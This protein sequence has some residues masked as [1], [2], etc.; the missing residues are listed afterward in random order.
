[1][2]L[3]ALVAAASLALAIWAPSAGAAT[4][5]WPSLSVSGIWA[6]LT[7]SDT[8][9]RVPGQ[10]LGTADGRTDQVPASVTRTQRN[11][12]GTAPGKG[13]GQLPAYGAHSTAGP[14]VTSGPDTHVSG[15]NSKTS[16]LVPSDMTATQDVYQNSNGTYTRKVYAGP[17]N[18]ETS[19]GSYAPIDTTLVS[20]GGRWQ[21]KANSLGVSFAPTSGAAVLGSMDLGG[22]ESYGFGLA[23]ATA[24]TGTQSGSSVTYPGVLA[25]TDLQETASAAGLSESLVLHSAAAPS[26][27]IFPLTL[28]GLTPTLGANGSVSLVNSA[29]T[30]VV[31]IPAGQAWDSA[32]GGR[33]GLPAN[34]VPTTWQLVS[35]NGSPALQL[36]LPAGWLSDPSRVFP[37]TVDPT[38]DEG[39]TGTTYAEHGSTDVDNSGAALMPVGTYDQGADE[40]LTFLAFGNLGDLGLGG[41]H[42]T[43]ASLALFDAWAWQ[44][45][46]AEE[47]DAYDITSPWSLT[48]ITWPGPSTGSEMGSLSEVAPTAACTNS[49]PPN[50]TVGGWMV[51][52]LNST[53]VADINAWTSYGLG[54][55]GSFGMMLSAANVGSTGDPAWKQFDGA[56][57]GASYEPFLE[58]TYATDTPPQINAVYPQSNYNA[59]SLTPEL[60]ASGSD[61]GNGP[62]PLGYY[63]A[64][65]NSAGTLVAN[66]TSAT[67]PGSAPGPTPVCN[68]SSYPTGWLSAPDWTVPENEL[69][70]GQTYYWTAV[71]CDGLY[72]GSSQAAYLTTQVPQPTVGQATQ[73]S[74][75]QGV[76][77]GGS[78]YT[79][80]ATDAQVSTIGPSLSIERDYDSQNFSAVGAFGAGWSSILDMKVT[81]ALTDAAGNTDTVVVTYPD[82]SQVGFG[83]N[84]DGSFTAPEGRYATLASVSGGYTLTDKNDT[85]YAFTQPLGGGAYGISSITDALGNELAFTWNSSDEITQMTSASGRSLSISWATPS[86]AQN[87]HVSS[88]STNPVTGTDQ[89][90]DLTWTYGYSGDELT[91]VC[92]PISTTACTTYSYTAGTDYPDAVLATS[93]HSYWRLDESSGATAASS[94]LVN[95]QTDAAT[96]SNVTLGAPGPLP[97]ST[98]TAA[99][100]NGSSSYVTL[101]SSL[102]PGSSYQS[103]SLWFKTNGTNGANEVLLG[104]QQV[105]LSGS[106]SP[107]PS[108]PNLYIGQDGKLIGEFWGLSAPL[109]SS[110]SVT[111]GTWYLATLVK[112]GSTAYLY[113]DGEQVA[114]AAETPDDL[115]WPYDYVGAGY[116]GAGWPDETYED[117]D[118]GTYT[119]TYFNGSI[120]DVAIW[121]RDLTGPEI[122]ALYQAGS[123]QADQLS[124]V[125]RPSGSV[126]A[127]VAYSTVTGAVSQVT[128]D[129]GGTWK[130][131]VPTVNYSSQVYVASVL[132]QAPTDYWRLGDTETSTAVNQVGGGG[133]ATYN[134]V[135]QGV[136]GPF[137]DSTADSF[138]GTSSY[139]QLPVADQVQTGSGSVEMWFQVPAGNTAGGVL[140][141][142][143][144]APLGPNPGNYNPALYVGTD[145]KLHGG[146]WA[147][148][149]NDQVV[150]SAAVNDGKWHMVVLTTS[151]TSESL[152]LDGKLLGTLSDAL[153][154]TG[155]ADVYVGAGYEYLWPDAPTNNNYDGYFTGS[156]SDVAFF[157]TQLSAAQVTAQWQAAGEVEPSSQGYVASVLRQAPAD[158]WRL[159]DTGTSTAVNQVSDGGTATYNDVAEGVAGPFA[160]ST[161]DSFNGTSSYLQ[162]PV[163]D[164]VQT[165]SGSVEMWFRVPAGNTAGGVLWDEMNSALGQSPTNWAPALYVGTDGILHGGFW[166]GSTSDQVVS[167]SAVNDGKWHMVVLTTS[168]TDEA[169]Y[170]DGQLLGTLPDELQPTGVADIY[171]GAGYVASWPDA[172]ANSS[173]YFTGSI[174]DVASFHTELSAAQVTAQWQAAQSAQGLT[175]VETQTVTDPG[176]H[177]ISYQMDPLNEDRIIAQTDALGDTTTFGYDSNGFQDSVTDP[178]GN[179]TLTGHDV[180]GNV[181]SQTTCQDWAAQDCSTE[182]MTYYP[183]DTSATLSPSPMNDLMLSDAGPGSASATDPTYLTTYT[184]TSLGEVQTETGPPVPGFPSGRT[185][186]YTYSCNPAAEGCTATPAY[187]SSGQQSGTTPPGLQLTETTPG[188]AVTSTEYY[189]DG[190]VYQVTDPDGMRTV[191]TYD[192][193]GRMLTQTEYSSSY[194]AGLTTTYAYDQMGQVV[195]ETDPTVT[196]PLPGTPHTALTT[197]TYDP[198]G[199]VLSQTVSDTTPASEGGDPARTVTNTYNSHDQLASTTDATG[200]KTSYTYDAYGNM[201]TKT[202]PA[203]NVTDYTYDADGDLLT[204]VLANYT[205]TAAGSCQTVSGGLVESSRTYDPAG[206]LASETNA[207]CDTTAYTYT[208]NGL[209]S[210]VTQCSGWTAS[211]GC[212]GSTYVEQANTYNSAGQLITQVTDNGQ[213]TTDYA[214][215]AAGQTESQTLD[216]A[217]LDRTTTYSYSPDDAVLNQKVFGP[218]SS[219]PPVTSVT[220]QA[221]GGGGGGS[222]S[223]F[224]D[225]CAAPGGGGGEYASQS[226]A[227]IPGATY[228][229]VVGAGGAGGAAG[230]TTGNAGGSSSFT[231]ESTVTA[232]GGGAGSIDDSTNYGGAGG[233]GGSNTTRYTGGAGGSGSTTSI[234]RGGGGGGSGGTS[235]VGNAGASG[236]TSGYGG[237]AVTGGGA[238]GDGGNA[239]SSTDADAP[240]S[241]GSAPGGGG[242]GGQALDVN[243]PG[244]SGAAGQVT[245]T[246]NGGSET[247][248][249]PGTYQWTAPLPPISLAS[250]TGYTYDPMGNMTS[251]T[252]H[253]DNTSLIP[254]GWWPLN[255]PAGTPSG[256]SSESYAPD[257]SGNGN[258]GI[259][260]AGA[261]WA[262]GGGVALD[263]NTGAVTTSGPAV[264]TT[265]S[266]TV[267]AWVN[268]NTMPT[269]NWAVAAQDGSNVSGFA[270]GY[271]SG[272][273][274]TFR[275]ANSD[276]QN[277]SF[278]STT[279]P[280]AQPGTWT[281]LVG[282]YNAV[283]NTGSLYINGTLSGSFAITPWSANGPFTIGSDEWNGQPADNLDGSIANVQAYPYALSASQVSQ[284]YGE[285]QSGAPLGTH[286]QTTSW[287]L[288][289][290]GLPTSMTDPD[291]N[292]TSYVYDQA[293]Q[294]AETTDPVVTTQV[295]GVGALA[296][297]P[298]SYTGYNTFGEPVLTKDAD[299]NEVVTDYDNDGRA[300]SVTEPDY[301]PPDG[302]GEIT[303]AQS[304]TAYNSLGEVTS[305]TDPLGN[306]TSYT[307]DQLGNVT[308]ET[309]PAG[310]TSYTYDGDG[311]Q[312]SATSPTGAVT[313]STYDFLGRQVTSTQVERYP[314]QASYTTVSAYGP[315]GTS[316]WLTSVT[317]P[318][319]V[320][321]SY[322]HDA[323]GEQ[324]SVT[325]GAGDTTSYAYD[326]AGR[327]TQT[328]NPDGT[329]TTTTYAEAGNPIGTSDYSSDG[330]LLR[331]DSATYDADGNQLTATDY[332]GH[333]TSFTYNAADELTGEIQP[334]TATS[335]VTTAFGYDA[336]GNQTLYTDGNGNSWWTTY[337]SW[338]LPESQ[339]EPETAAAPTAADSTFTTSYNAD[340]SPLEVSEPGGITITDSY[341][342]MQELTGQSGSGASAA[343]TSRSFGYNADGELTSAS[344]PG[345]TD[346]Y[347]YDDRGLLL[348]A[349]GPSGTSSF[350]YNGDGLLSS[351]A[352]AAGTTSYSYDDA[353]RLSTLSDP[354]TGTTLSYAYTPDSQVSQITYG[355]GGDV[356]AYG[357]NGLHQLSSDTLQTAGGAS[358]ASIS[359]GYDPDGNLTSKDT[360]GFG[361]AADNTY[362]YN[363]ASELTSWDNGTTTTDYAYDGAGNRTQ[364]GSKTYTYDARDELTSDGTS[365]YSY[366]MAGNLASVSGPSG[367]TSYTSDAFGQTITAAGQTYAYDALGRL[368]SDTGS[369]GS[370]YTF[371]YDGTSQTLASDGT[372]TYTWD[373]GGTSLVGIGTP[374]GTTSEGVLALTDAHTDLV[375]NFTPSGSSLTASA[376]YDPLGNILTSTGMA[377]H[378]GYQSAWTDPAT[379]EAHMGARWYDPATGQFTSRDTAHVNPEPNSAAANPFAYAAD[380]PLT[381]TDPTGHLPIQINAGG[382]VGS[383][384]YCSGVASKTAAAPKAAA[385]PP[386]SPPATNLTGLLASSP[387]TAGVVA[388]AVEAAAKADPGHNTASAPKRVA[389]P[390]D[391][392]ALI[393]A[394][395]VRI[396]P[397]VLAAAAAAQ[398]SLTRT[399]IAGL[400][401]PLHLIPTATHP[402]VGKAE[403]CTLLDSG[404]CL[405]C[406]SATICFG[407]GTNLNDGSQA[408]K[409]NDQFDVPEFCALVEDIGVSCSFLNAANDNES[410]DQGNS[411]GTSG[412][413]GLT[414][415]ALKRLAVDAAQQEA[416]AAEEDNDLA[417]SPMSQ[418]DRVGS[419]LKNDLYHRAVSWVVG[420]PAAEQFTFTSGDGVERTLYQVEGELNGKPGVFEWIVDD[421]D[422][423]PVINHQRFIPDG[424]ISGYPNQKP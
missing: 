131:G 242:G 82:G 274:W 94:V 130:I 323:A 405:P 386:S 317:T 52:P 413:G 35:Y 359:Y 21:E 6:W 148:S 382:C 11:G 259:F 69:S 99:S 331:S 302:S 399:S 30:A 309:T 174:S 39:V 32:P 191:Y 13:P 269:G 38:G 304:T 7:A 227:V 150:S 337:N 280:A 18:Y 209:T 41:Y 127:Q 263:G 271:W 199:D 56:A 219:T 86:G 420:D 206:Q 415:D 96:Y 110:S 398:H 97:G 352:D 47:F 8:P 92:P 28:A 134:D 49:N 149:V 313:D 3:A 138:N 106:S 17:V 306:V 125:T 68:Q 335:S 249:T 160:D 114:S 321:T 146:F 247:W 204:Q 303:N 287:T 122:S 116:L 129:N 54:N 1:M 229:V 254:S 2:R 343:T 63:F 233:T 155:V 170:L 240:G 187:N 37:V 20:S 195:S 286:L 319:L 308:S 26:S 78:D 236:Q 202:D 141:D 75:T 104:T 351:V 373:P 105:P 238:G 84:Y 79:T 285:G 168:G 101:P 396:L 348:S 383:I 61:P 156:I 223:N 196:D 421:S 284:L 292:T 60:Q 154:T 83:E 81:P 347:T 279:G 31:V 197:T 224:N 342:S 109:E 389:M 73:N 93:P 230:T 307:Y 267:S 181:V 55:Q 136:A 322:T 327:L 42:L 412:D 416:E 66:S 250:V 362:T 193:L 14:T 310:T 119:A 346:S 27:W 368:V 418:M 184:Y 363:D 336:A 117:G 111:N 76:R 354:A 379:S 88:V 258:T 325:D 133:T 345:G 139:L 172:P 25:D 67:T 392:A 186:T 296:V 152:Y 314:S 232:D 48:S 333:T 402:R 132:Q 253:D 374:G 34:L 158:Y 142:E 215:D 176:G 222:G 188:G 275:F 183:D 108:Q 370:G 334:V 162:L 89:S 244:G 231:G 210:T 22:G 113:L 353:D 365:T 235:S 167:P 312:L 190:D 211:T 177:T 358:V 64:V 91:S 380:N 98:A 289:Q 87:P 59:T 243:E 300:V 261:S 273:G 153:Q 107:G 328:T 241:A 182:Y 164:Q 276:V 298:V 70:W 16:R 58:L 121:D 171:V 305:L 361:T 192:G 234:Y 65:Y 391:A 355:T 179:V 290:R 407:T 339:I 260:S 225:C 401:E 140:W 350:A 390:A 213:T 393:A 239:G 226:V 220:A 212:G 266:F 297:A 198:D 301:T 410:S 340:G 367:T 173:G 295:H 161:A 53:G 194:P 165:G 257:Q 270:L 252:V 118:S 143:Q 278:T 316:P 369:T 147:G 338:N 419:A 262:S 9:A 200:D 378:L 366:T 324:T 12:A 46:T 159:G 100:F 408:S 423:I 214:M 5:R 357:Y 288:D 166:A 394:F 364:V 255:A 330:T 145:G 175:P 151:G 404:P 406:P 23:G 424:T 90:T 40:A 15:F 51:M 85:V 115:S 10:A 422:D 72:W 294:L 157:H 135:T 178:D 403:T 371:S 189:A 57:D 207:N 74:G 71:D 376:V 245:L 417:D 395:K 103:I 411:T 124:Q 112:A 4:L 208:G 381:G 318:D 414:P 217:G 163:A 277:A 329:S 19:S 120:S 228:T 283:T 201:A 387:R 180:R 332:D 24:V 128:D 50:P 384:A 272:S 237:A 33:S 44:C 372:S 169:L 326:A 320:T 265:S 80:S 349:S 385:P 203:G 315:T 62:D 291:G 248:S 205:G 282:V 43:A 264:S 344:A 144:D 221:W 251:E 95:E 256:S 36:N 45:T 216:P 29:G 356:Q 137:A 400:F 388:Q 377:G 102:L 126:Y 311:D 409:A 397:S 281:H 299:G 123:N 218:A 293:G 341:N 360:T 77:P 375:G 185:T 268:V 246:W